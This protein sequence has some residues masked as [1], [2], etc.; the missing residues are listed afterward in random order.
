MS[1]SIKKDSSSFSGTPVDI[2]LDAKTAQEVEEE[3][4]AHLGVKT[5]EA[6][7]KVYGRY[8]K[9]FLFAG[10]VDVSELII[11]HY[12]HTDFRRLG[13]AS[14]IYSLDGSTTYTYLAYATSAF[15]DHSLISSIQV[16][17]SVIGECTVLHGACINKLT[18]L[19]WLSVNPLLQ[20]SPTSRP[21]APPTLLF[22]SN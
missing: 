10:Y 13:L 15:G 12:L 21:E 16:A 11:N 9:W 18:S 19:Q 8:S 2:I 7:E 20:S 1:S 3:Q 22:V 17:Q 5:V 14:Y 6:A 4:D